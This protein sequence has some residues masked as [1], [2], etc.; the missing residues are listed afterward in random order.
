MKDKELVYRE[1]LIML[2]DIHCYINYHSLHDFIV[3]RKEKHHEYRIGGKFG[4]GFKLWYRNDFV[5][6]NFLSFTQYQEDITE[7]SDKWIVRHNE[8]LK[9]ICKEY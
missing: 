9:S 8:Y 7:E 1:V 5:N 2:Q 6:G 4:M 3:E